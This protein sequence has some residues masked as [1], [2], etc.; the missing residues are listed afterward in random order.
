M[1]LNSRWLWKRYLTAFQNKAVFAI[2]KRLHK[3]QNGN[4][5]F[6]PKEGQRGL[7]CSNKVPYRCPSFGLNIN[8]GSSEDEALAY[9]ADVLVEAYFERKNHDPTRHTNQ[10][11]SS[12]LLSRLDN[13]TS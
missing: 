1:I 5:N 13:G 9:L 10:Q 7:L 4:P 6:E 12:P 3:R 8:A 2:M 11:T